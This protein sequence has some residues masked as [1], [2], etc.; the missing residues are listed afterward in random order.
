MARDDVLRI[1]M[2]MMNDARNTNPWRLVHRE[3][4]EY[5]LDDIDNIQ[6]MV[7]MPTIANI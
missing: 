6:A 2:K 5:A 7:M 1:F 4:Q 3:T